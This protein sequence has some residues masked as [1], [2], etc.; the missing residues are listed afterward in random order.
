[1]NSDQIFLKLKKAWKEHPGYYQKTKFIH[2][3]RKTSFI[4]PRFSSWSP[5]NFFTWFWLWILSYFI[6]LVFVQFCLRFTNM[7]SEFLIIGLNIVLFIGLIWGMI[8]EKVRQNLSHVPIEKLNE[9]EAI[10]KAYPDLGPLI[11]RW[12]V[13]HCFL[14]GDYIRFSKQWTAFEKKK[15]EEELDQLKK[16]DHQ[17]QIMNGPLGKWVQEH[18]VNCE[19]THLNE[20]FPDSKKPSSTQRI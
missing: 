12:T 9:I 16:Y 6:E 13:N 15:K 10:I 14:Q 3:I 19:K 2:W 20:I 5:L 8:S 11:A 18:E 7:Q 17:C 1:M 4:L